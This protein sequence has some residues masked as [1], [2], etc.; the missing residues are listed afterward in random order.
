MK[1]LVERNDDEARAELDAMRLRIW[2]GLIES[3]QYVL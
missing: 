1:E 3:E 2:T